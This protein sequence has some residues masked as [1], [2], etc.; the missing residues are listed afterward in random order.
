MLPVDDPYLTTGDQ[1]TVP[2]L[3]QFHRLLDVQDVEQHRISDTL[4]RKPTSLGYEI[5]FPDNDIRKG[6]FCCT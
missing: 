3:K 4:V 1:H 6:R 2:F 5:S